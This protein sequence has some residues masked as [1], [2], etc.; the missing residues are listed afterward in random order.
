[1]SENVRETDL[2]RYLDGEMPPEERRRF[3]EALARSTE[4]QRDLALF[5]SLKEEVRALEL[6]GAAPSGSV[7]DRVSAHLFRPAGWAFLAVG[8]LAWLAY[9]I[10]V[11]TTAPIDPWRRLAVAAVAIGVLLLFAS[12]IRDRMRE[13]ATDPYKHV[14]R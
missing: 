13:W 10:H 5:R 12:V 11:F 14:R 2:M 8:L 6:P 7:W 1:M 4:L 3:E 9:G